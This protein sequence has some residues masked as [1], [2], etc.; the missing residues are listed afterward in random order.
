MPDDNVPATG[1]QPG[2]S[3]N[4]QAPTEF[5]FSQ[6]Q[7]WPQWKKRFDRYMSVSG[8]C[9]K[10]DKEKIDML[11]YLM[12]NEAEEIL[13]QQNLSGNETYTDILDK[14]EKYFIP[15][16]NII[17]E[18]F[19]F[20]SRVQK[21]GEPV[22]NFIT[23]LHA[24]AEHCGYGT[25]KEELIRDRI[26]IGVADSKVSERLQ[27]RDKL[28]LAE[29]ITAVRQAELQNTQNKILR[30]E[31]SVCTVK[32]KYNKKFQYKSKEK[33]TTT[34]GNLKKCPYCG[35]HMCED[36][37][38]CPA[39]TSNCRA[40]GKRG[41]WSM[42][43]RS[44]K[45]S[46]Q[47]V[48]NS[49][50]DSSSE[51]Q[52]DQ[53]VSQVIKKT[54]NESFIGQV[55]LDRQDRWYVDILL[56]HKYKVPFFVDTGADVNCFPYGML[57]G[58]FLHKI[59]PCDPVGA[60]DDHKLDTVGRIKLDMTY[61]GS[62][63]KEYIYVIR[64][65]RQPILCR[66]TII[67]FNVLNF[68]T[69]K[70]CFI[71]GYNFDCKENHKKL[72]RYSLDLISQQFQGIFSDIGEF[73]TEMSIQIKSDAKP[74]VQSVPRTVPLALLPKLKVE[75]DRLLKLDII[76]KIEIPTAWVSPIVCVD[77]GDTVRL[78]CDYTKLNESVL[79]SHFPLPKI[80]HTLAQLGGS[81]YFSKLDAT[82]GF[83]QIKLNKESQLLTTFITPYGR[84]FFKRLPF[85][86]SCAPE[87]FALNF[88]KILTGLEGVVYHMDDVLIHASSMEKHDEILIRV[89]SKLY[90][91][92]ITLNPKKCVIGVKSIK[93]LGHLISED[94]ISVDPDRVEA[95][96]EFPIPE[97]KT[98]VMRLLGMINFTAKYINNKSELLEPLTALLKKDRDF[99]WGPAQDKAFNTIKLILEKPPN[100]AFFDP[101]KTIIVSADASSFGLGCCLMQENNDK[102]REIVAFGSRLLSEAETRY[103]QIEKEALALTWAAEHFSDYISGVRNLIFESDHKP[104]LQILQTKNL[105]SLTPRLQRFRMRLMRYK[106]TIIYTP[107]K[108]LIIP[109]TL[110]RGPIQTQ[111]FNGELQVEVD[112]FVKAVIKNLPVKPDFMKLI[113]L[114]QEQDDIC[115]KLKEYSILSWPEK[116]KLPPEL[117]PYYQHRYD[118]SFS[119]NLLLK[120]TRIIIPKSL[121][122]KVLEFIHTG[123]LGIVKCRER[124][125]MSVWWIGLSTQIEN[126]VKNCP[127][128]IENRQNIK[129]T[130]YK[131]KTVSRPWQKI[132]VDFFK[133]DKWYMILVD[134]YS[135]YFEIF[136]LNSLTEESIIPKMKEVFSRFGIPE[137]VRSD[138][139]TQFSRKFREFAHIYDFAH[140]TCSPKFS[141]SNGGG[142]ER[143]V[144]TAKRLIKKNRDDIFLALLA[145]R[146]SPLEHGFSPSE[147][148]MNRKLRST[149]PILPSKLEETLNTKSEFLQKEKYLK[150]K[151]EKNYNKRHNAK[152]MDTLKIGDSVWVVDIR[153]YGR[154]VEVCEEP[155][156]YIVE[157]DVGQY[158][159]NRWH[160]VL[161]PYYFP[162]AHT[163][164][165]ILPDS[166]YK[167]SS[168]QQ[169]YQRG[170]DTS[171]TLHEEVTYDDSIDEEPSDSNDIL[172][173]SESEHSKTDIAN[174]A[175]LSRPKRI[176]KK[177]AYLLDYVN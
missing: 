158:R 27:L 147:L 132:A 131:D 80:Q 119:E 144:Q 130:F 171:N 138:N 150:N 129:E 173:Q 20:N 6:P 7:Q 165:P 4:V 91:E 96:R 50:S 44:N 63:N 1:A 22:E 108:N 47:V 17:F 37:T 87:Y 98:D 102:S 123:H 26:V 41:H 83:Y 111:K 133:H 101:N 175:P 103:A 16:R 112:T 162:N 35:I 31:Q 122:L 5:N 168:S 69:T 32:T 117:F 24:L 99:L 11:I 135:R 159:R 79:R 105:D 95:I 3:A 160:L 114:E 143:A 40:C 13:L 43:C 57:P 156:S 59:N 137:V 78:C 48:G 36:R 21:P 18:R 68:P 55:Y 58:E 33:L 118:I 141:Q 73:K 174:T 104:L 107:G 71:N 120:D 53:N 9:K 128:C 25:L 121:Q 23:S 115:K 82:S 110:S 61:E 76:E 94:G 42:V 89:L 51:E 77:K 177:P 113:K 148:L 75:L 46:V 106:Y 45:K 52:P 166:N 54:G 49:N 167:V 72:S 100:L 14:F 64:K 38:K 67:R 34:T 126:L 152:N 157:T 151:L 161:A 139:G 39:K 12:G 136:E 90:S 62:T 116:S 30:Q 28:T 146:T 127:S 153:K 10:L 85:G 125:K 140:V 88:S 170:H 97:N 163:E 86:I 84:F 56:N 65:L 154:V 70:I 8:F 15:Q 145:Y 169:N 2:I 124:A 19:Q 109:D 74:F 66:N 172:P 93:Y 149:L 81:K 155:R 134:Y 176:V 142:V 60:A 29:A 164:S 92:G